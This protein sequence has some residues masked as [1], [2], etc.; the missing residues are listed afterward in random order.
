MS[1]SLCVC[2][3]RTKLRVNKITLLLSNYHKHSCVIKNV[4]EFELTIFCLVHVFPTFMLESIFTRWMWMC[5]CV[6]VP[7]LCFIVCVWAL[8]KQQLYKRAMRV[9]TWINDRTYLTCEF[10]HFSIWKIVTV[11]LTSLHQTIKKKHTHN[12]QA[13]ALL[14]F[15]LRYR[16][17]GGHLHLNHNHQLFIYLIH[18]TTN[19]CFTCF[20]GEKKH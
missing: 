5:V 10:I 15:F 11:L 1:L 17:C 16:V 18:L 13:I 2:K 19:I 20:P 3:I 9:T 4:F 12:E 8:T 7:V 14:Y 6:C